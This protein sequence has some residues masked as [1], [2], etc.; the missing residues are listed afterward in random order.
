MFICSSSSSSKYV[1]A[2][3]YTRYIAGCVSCSLPSSS[4]VVGEEEEEEKMCVD[5]GV[6]ITWLVCARCTSTAVH[7]GIQ[8]VPLDSPSFVS[9]YRN[10]S[11]SSKSVYA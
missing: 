2:A 6:V 11:Y 1:S 9:S 5:G 10:V 8:C 7:I 4:S 3:G